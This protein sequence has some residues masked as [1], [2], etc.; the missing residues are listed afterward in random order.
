MRNCIIIDDKEPADEIKILEAEGIK[1]SFPVKCHYF[2]PTKKEYC[3]L[4]PV[5]GGEK[6]EAIDLHLVLKGLQEEYDGKF[7]ISLIA[8]DY[9]FEDPFTDG[10]T[11]LQFLK[12][13]W[14]PKVPSIVYSTLS[15]TIKTNLQQ[16]IKAIIDDRD[17]LADFLESYYENN[18]ND[19]FERSN[20]SNDI[21][22]FLKKQKTSS[23]TNLLVEKLLENPNYKFRNIS[24]P[25]EGYTLRAIERA[26]QKDTPES[27][28][29]K[30]EF[31][32]RAIAHFVYLKE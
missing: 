5:L 4:T 14:R 3:K 25:F 17:A 24:V 16:E 26:I 22:I 11:L 2:N 8:S 6:K 9:N 13:E 19:T 27:I 12:Q 18:P 32:E 23:F 20:F 30:N 31:L 21:L 7:N 10:L 1:T 15:K 29:F 28:L